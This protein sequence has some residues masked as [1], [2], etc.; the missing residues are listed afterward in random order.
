MNR[1]SSFLHLQNLDRLDREWLT[2]WRLL[3]MSLWY[4]YNDDGSNDKYTGNDEEN[5]DYS[6]DDDGDNNDEFDD[7]V[8]DDEDDDDY[9]GDKCV[10]DDYG[11][12]DFSMDKRESHQYISRRK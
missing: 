7:D 4:K 1:K 11:D 9:K 10:G 3:M 5:D 6:K 8:D 2:I 12:F